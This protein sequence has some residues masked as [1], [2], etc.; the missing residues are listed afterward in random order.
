VDLNKAKYSFDQVDYYLIRLL[1][2]AL[3][4]ISAY[5]L[6]E[7]ETRHKPIRISPASTLTCPQGDGETNSGSTASADEEAMNAPE[8]TERHQKRMVQR[9]PEHK[10][11]SA[12]RNYTTSSRQ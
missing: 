4:L 2:V 10:L 3:F 8:W 5:K 6:V 12:K 11:R 7:L 9:Q 1:Q